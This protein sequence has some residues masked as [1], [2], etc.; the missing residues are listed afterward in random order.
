M[1]VISKINAWI[2]EMQLITSALRKVYLVSCL[3][4]SYKYTV[5][6]YPKQSGSCRF[7]LWQVYLVVQE[8]QI[9]HTNIPRVYKTHKDPRL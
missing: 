9:Q 8:R 4:L 2:A 1:V 7:F 3:C 6:N 5:K